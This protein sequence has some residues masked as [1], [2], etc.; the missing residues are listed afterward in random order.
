MSKRALILTARAEGRNETH[1]RIGVFQ[2]G[3]KAGVLTVDADQEAAVL[4]AINAQADL[5]AACE[6]V[7]RGMGACI[8]SRDFVCAACKC[9]EA[10]R[11]ATQL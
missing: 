4:G 8:C 6:A 1:A 11:M 10:I 3:G 7:V 5:L 2:N 9:R